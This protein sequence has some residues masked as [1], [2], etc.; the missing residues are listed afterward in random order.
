M[1]RL[2]VFF[3]LPVLVLPVQAQ[4]VQ[5]VNFKPNCEAMKIALDA[6]IASYGAKHHCS[7]IDILAV[8]ACRSGG[9]CTADAVKQAAAELKTGASPKKILKE[10]HV[11]YDYYHEAYT[12]VLGGLVGKFAIE[13]DGKWITHYGLKAYSPIAE[14]YPYSHVSDY[15]AP[16]SYGYSR[17]HL[18]NDLMGDLGTPIVAVET[19]TVE[20]I[21]WNPYGGWRVGIRSLDR[22][23]YCYYAHMRKD[24]PYAPGLKEGDLVR[25][26]DVIGFM[27]RTG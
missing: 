21:G 11:F 5:W 20:A 16:R 27:G 18:G 1:K 23:R 2:F 12:A 17:P 26:G 8:A 14:G 10:Q 9:E 15:G 6:D 3:L 24:A 22:K 19:G 25:A 7:W 13:K 4:S